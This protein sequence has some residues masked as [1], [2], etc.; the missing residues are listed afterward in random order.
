[1]PTRASL[2]T[3]ADAPSHIGYPCADGNL[4]ADA[5]STF[6]ASGLRKG[7]AVVL[8]TTEPRRQTIESRLEA[9]GCDTKASTNTGQ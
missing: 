7:D 9:G 2:L 4:I 5:V 8:V 1:M 6:A 3:D